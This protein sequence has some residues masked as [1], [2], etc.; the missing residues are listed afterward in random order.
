M[1]VSQPVTVQLK[2]SDGTCW[3]ATYTAPASAN[4][5]GKFV[6]RSD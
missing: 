3:E 5:P 2:S 4:G 1:P 6:D